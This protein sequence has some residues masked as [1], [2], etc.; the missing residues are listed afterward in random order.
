MLK[1]PRPAQKI[2]ANNPELLKVSIKSAKQSID[3][4]GRGAKGKRNQT[5]HQKAP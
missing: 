4:L 3:H 5:D 2:W 1:I